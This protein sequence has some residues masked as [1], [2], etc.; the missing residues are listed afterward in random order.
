MQLNKQQY[1]ETFEYLINNHV[2]FDALQ[3]ETTPEIFIEATIDAYKE[4]LRTASLM[5]LYI[6]S[7]NKEADV[8]KFARKFYGIEVGKDERI[9][10][11]MDMLIG[12]KG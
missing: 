9:Q 8:I 2:D 7:N 6:L 1:V 5:G 12:L 11:L 4:A 3:K 10:Q